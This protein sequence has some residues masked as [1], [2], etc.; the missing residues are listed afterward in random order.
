M[1]WRRKRMSTCFNLSRRSFL[2]PDIRFTSSAKAL[3]TQT[4]KQPE[5]EKLQTSCTIL[6]FKPERSANSRVLDKNV[7]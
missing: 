7:A 3:I 6:A 1:K 5:V 4:T 2:P